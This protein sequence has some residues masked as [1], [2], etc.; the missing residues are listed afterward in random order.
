MIRPGSDADLTIV[1]PKTSWTVKEE[2]LVAKQP[3]SA[4][5]GFDL[6]GIPTIVI[7]RGEVVMKDRKP[8]STHRGRFV[9]ARHDSG[10][11]QK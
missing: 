6:K 10:G 7:L 4:W 9:A 5:K 1:D 3:T 8:V 11:L 2:E